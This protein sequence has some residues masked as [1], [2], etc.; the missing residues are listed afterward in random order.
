MSE[1]KIYAGTS[2]VRVMEIKN[3]LEGE[4]ISFH[5]MNKMDST[6]AGI[7]GEIQLFVA[8]ADAEKAE[9]LVAGI[10]N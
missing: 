6:Y 5:E 4:G 7:F 1:I 9:H 2:Q 8:E 3:L 10:K